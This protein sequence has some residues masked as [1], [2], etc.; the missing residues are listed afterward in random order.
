MASRKPRRLGW[1]STCFIAWTDRKPTEDPAILRAL[2]ETLH[3]MIHG[4]VQIVASNVIEV[5]VRPGDLERT[6][7]LH[8]RLRACPHFE[9]FS[10]GPTVQRLARESQDRLQQSGRIGHYADLIH[11]ATAI[12]AKAEEFGTTDKRVVRGYSE[13]VIADIMMCEPYLEQDVLDLGFEAGMH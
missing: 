1:D 11:V 8:Q 12:G 2:D 10:V 6:R 5:E 4:R 7:A 13:R 9:S 3:Q